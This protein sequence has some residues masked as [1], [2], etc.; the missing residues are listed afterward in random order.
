MVTDVPFVD[1]GW[2]NRQVADDVRRGID[3][4]I[5]TCS[6]VGGPDVTEFETSFA[7]ACGVDHCVG[8]GNG[9]DAIEL[10][11]MALGVGPGDAV[12]VPAN[13]FVATAEAVVRTGAR[14][15]F[16]DVDPSHLLMSPSSLESVCVAH[17]P[18]VV[19][20]VDLYGQIAPLAELGRI[21]E[22]HGAALVEDAAQA[23]GARQNERGIGHGVAIATTSF[24][25]GKNLGAFGDAGAVITRSEE[26]ADSVRLLANHGSRVRYHHEV[27]GRNS[28]LDGMQAVVLNAKLAHLEEWNEM[29]RVAATRYQH[30]LGGEASIR[31][32]QTA[33]GNLHAWHLYVIRTEHRDDVARRLSMSNVATAIHYP[34][35]IHLTPAFERTTDERFPVA[36][37]A[38]AQI[39]SLPMFPG[40]SEAQQFR[41]ADAVLAATRD[42]TMST[43]A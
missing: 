36:E 30:L 42:T 39:L 20:A 1:L 2:Q 34:V 38:A 18:R 13:T 35:P 3:S 19:I 12:A 37:M 15:V 9:T 41:V 5:E 29:R 40:I 7:S 28:R 27:V 21:A 33:P 8:V 16:V 31:L 32:P 26:L 14:C 24:Y 4:V 23:Q 6:F 11:L 25:P 17:R 43:T 22:A 10:A